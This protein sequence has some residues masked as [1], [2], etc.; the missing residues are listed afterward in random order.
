MKRSELT[1]DGPV[2]EGTTRHCDFVP[3]GGVNERIV[4]YE[5]GRRMT[6]HLYE[7]FKMPASDATADFRLAADR[8][9]TP[10]SLEVTYTAN[11]LGRA[12]KRITDK[13]MRKGMSAMADDLA[14]EAERIDG[15]S[16]ARRPAM[17]RPEGIVDFTP[18]PELYPFDLALVREQCRPYPLHRR[19]RGSPAGAVPR[20][21]GLELPLPGHHLPAARI[22]SAASRWTIPA[23]GCPRTPVTTTATPRPN[24][25][26]RSAN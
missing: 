4:G 24:T 26:R 20:Q 3:M 8:E 13:Q 11:R 17:T 6:V 23:S 18:D 1:S 7:M 14:R 9:A 16:S 12:A 21:P 22:S 25:P 15:A 19:G 5:P 10:L 2:G